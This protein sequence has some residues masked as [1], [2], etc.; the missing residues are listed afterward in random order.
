MVGTG[1]VLAQ[2]SSS[3][4][5]GTTPAASNL[6]LI[7][8]AGGR[9]NLGAAPTGT[10]LSDWSGDGSRALLVSDLPA[11]NGSVNIYMY[12]LSTGSVSSFAVYSQP[13]VLNVHFTRPTGQGVLV[14]GERT[15]TGALPTQRFSLTGALQL[16]YPTSYPG[17]GN[18]YGSFIES[19]DG[20]SLIFQ[21]ASGLELVSNSGQPLRFL[22]PPPGQTECN[23]LRWW[24][25]GEVLAGCPS[26]LWLIPVSGAPASPLTSPNSPGAFLN[27][28][29][30]PTGD[31]AEDAA[32]GTTWLESIHANGT[33][34]RLDVPDTTTNGSVAGLGTYGSEL[35][36]TLTPGCDGGR[37]PSSNAVAWYN[38]ATNGIRLLLGDGVN[39]G[40]VDGEVLFGT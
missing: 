13:Y 6:Y 19:P 22:P 28:W 8:P 33:T 21:G 37:G 18:D 5:M 40:W 12:D 14:P 16:S 23:P 39:G 2:W 4:P 29:S 17:A 3:L 10:T 11:T 31:V 34:S 32:C 35:A 15:Q 24:N 9:Y 20:T 38:P 27:A 1:W 25:D 7:D 36:I 26:Q 30:L